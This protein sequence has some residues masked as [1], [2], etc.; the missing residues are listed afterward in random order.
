MILF[1]K[2][3]EPRHLPHV[4]NVATKIMPLRDDLSSLHR[5]FEELDGRA[6][7]HLPDNLEC[8]AGHPY[9][10]VHRYI[11]TR[12][13]CEASGK[14]LQETAHGVVDARL[15]TFQVAEVESRL[16]SVSKAVKPFHFHT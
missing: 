7:G 12:C 6:I 1:Q 2:V 3:V 10:Q 8:E 5:T 16:N 15:V 9:R 4:L 14:L 13:V 11:L